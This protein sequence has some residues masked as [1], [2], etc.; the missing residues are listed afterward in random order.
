VDFQ[1][2]LDKLRELNASNRAEVAEHH[3]VC[4]KVVEPVEQFCRA[5]QR[6]GEIDRTRVEFRLD[7]TQFEIT[8]P[9]VVK[10]SEIVSLDVSIARS[11]QEED[12]G[13]TW[14]IAHS[15]GTIDA[16]G[17]VDGDYDAVFDTIVSRIAELRHAVHLQDRTV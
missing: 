1:K 3:R 12:S 8:V 14:K 17:A 11:G 15:T 9:R 13:Y 4:K 2:H 6:E 5:L 10:G 16:E 7:K